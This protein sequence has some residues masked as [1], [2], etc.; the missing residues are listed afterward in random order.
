MIHQPHGGVGGQVSDIEI[1]ANEIIRTRQALNE[2]M[3]THTGKTVEEIHKASD[4]DYYMTAAEGK[5]FGIV[6]DILLKQ[7]MPGGEAEDED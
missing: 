4:R 2:I 7:T 3:A 6:D 5:A 1:Q